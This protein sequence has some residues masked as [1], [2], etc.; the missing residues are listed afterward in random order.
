[1]KT[2]V[3]SIIA[4][5]LL[6]VIEDIK[7]QDPNWAWLTSMGGPDFDSVYEM[8]VDNQG[9][10]YVTGSLALDAEINGVDID[11]GKG[12]LMK[13][14]SGGSLLWSRSVDNP[15]VILSIIEGVGVD[16]EGNV[17][18]GIA[19]LGFPGGPA[20]TLEFA[21]LSLT[22]NSQTDKF[23]AKLDED[24]N[25]IWSINMHDPQ[26]VVVGFRNRLVV[27]DNDDVYFGS[28]LGSTNGGSI[29][30]GEFTILADEGDCM[31]LKVNSDGEAQWLKMLGGIGNEQIFDL[32]ACPG[33]GVIFCSNWY[34]ETL[35]IDG[36]ILT[37]P[38]ALE[39]ANPD[40]YIAKFESD[41]NLAWLVREGGPG[42]EE[43][44]EVCGTED[45]GAMVY[46]YV[47]GN[48]DITLDGQ[49]FNA[50]DQVLSRYSSSGELL[51]AKDMGSNSN[52]YPMDIYLDNAIEGP[53]YYLTYNFESAETLLNDV[54]LSNSAG[55]FGTSDAVIAQING[56]GDILWSTLIEGN[57]NETVNRI[58]TDMN[59]S[60]YV[61]GSFTSETLELGPLSAENQQIFSPDI[62]LARSNLNTS[63]VELKA[64]QLKVFPIPA[65]ESLI[66][67]LSLVPGNAQL[68]ITDAQ[69]RQ[70]L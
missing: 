39:G 26:G 4:V 12:I 60:L 22:G 43:R 38:D 25:G 5:M 23:I 6:L 64:E 62:F 27:D 33:G 57:E 28:S 13:F 66:V 68:K 7:A 47:Y 45:G 58:G 19:G 10:T 29:T 40:R 20:W 54:V 42:T 9:N 49:T 15:L 52:G 61:L 32:A 16:S 35:N 67:D 70:A 44:S 51:W 59:G 56:N 31:L 17:Y 36:S 63:I 65:R 41:G 50:G 24:G 3:K 21:G 11:A 18:V 48:G 69:G 53:S 30:V 37:N 46:S 8:V 1:M 55:E 34:G 14:N 2:I